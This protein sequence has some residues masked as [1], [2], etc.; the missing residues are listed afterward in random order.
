MAQ[1]SLFAHPYRE[2]HTL[3]DR[4]G[5]PVPSVEPRLNHPYRCLAHIEAV[6]TLMRAG[7]D[8]PVNGEHFE[9]VEAGGEYEWIDI[10][11]QA[12]EAA[13]LENDPH[14]NT[15]EGSTP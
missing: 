10:R 2:R 15:T 6:R 7:V 5:P 1:L 13:G 14:R 11:P 4:S 8:E 3:P 12:V 9:I